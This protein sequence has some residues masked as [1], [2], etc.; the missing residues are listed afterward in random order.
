MTI[1]N[2][3]FGQEREIKTDFVRLGNDSLVRFDRHVFDQALNRHLVEKA[4]LDS[5][6]FVSV[7]DVAV[8]DHVIVFGC[9]IDLAA[10]AETHRQRAGRVKLAALGQIGEIGVG[11][12]F[13]VFG[14]DE[15]PVVVIT[16]HRILRQFALLVYRNRETLRS[17]APHGKQ[18]A[19]FFGYTLE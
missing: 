4:R 15:K 6:Q 8:V 2:A 7:V 1:L 19:R 17:A 11:I 16:Q 9:R 18:F 5:A 14:K 13:E 10:L 3:V 12:G